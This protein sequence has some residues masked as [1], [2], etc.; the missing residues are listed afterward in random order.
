MSEPIMDTGTPISS[1]SPEEMDMG[2]S[3]GLDGQ[4]NSLMNASPVNKGS[5]NSSMPPLKQSARQRESELEIKKRYFCTACNKGFAR[6]YDWKVHEQRYHEQQAQYPCPDC[7]QVLYAETHFRSHHRDAHGCNQCT[8]AKEVTRE[9]DARRRRTAW[10]CGFCGE[11]LD[12]WE[13]RCDHISQHYDD[14]RK[15]SE[16]D[17]SKVIVGLLHQSDVDSAWQ[18]LLISKHGQH[19]NPP[20][21][22]RWSKETTARSHGDNLQLQDLLELGASDRDVH[23]MAQLAYEHGYRSPE[24]VMSSSLPTVG[25]ADEDDV[26]PQTEGPQDSVMASPTMESA[27]LPQQQQPQHQQSQPQ[28]QAQQ[29]YNQHFMQSPMQVAFTPQQQHH[30]VQRASM[31]VHSSP[32]TEWSP[33]PDNMFQNGGFM[34]NAHHQSMQPQSMQ[35]YQEKAL[36]P[37]P[38]TPVD[39]DMMLP[40]Q[41]PTEAQVTS[42]ETWSMMTG[43]TFADDS[44]AMMLP[45]F[46]PNNQF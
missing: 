20:L 15:R 36:P 37:L 21:M 23:A 2:Q 29:Q 28:Q 19:P 40:S 32:M 43:S 12:D 8:H 5:R 18:S 4:P 17:H 3:L 11:L 22:L 27:S 13:K 1:L 16:W 9:V 34:H 44:T 14:G 35:P 6:K 42:F 46:D 31:P 24:S 39:S 30:E 10:G 25:E 7:N 38:P 41:V 33:Y 45:T 26:S